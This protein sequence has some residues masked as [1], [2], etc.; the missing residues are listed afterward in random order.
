[1]NRFEKLLQTLC[2]HGVE[3]KAIKDI[4]MFRRG[5]FPQPYTRSKWYGG[6]NSMPFIQVIDVADTMKLNEKSKQSISKL[7]QPKSV[8]VPKGTVIV[9]LQGT[10]GKVAITQYDSYI[11]RTI[12]IFTSYR[13]N[14]DKKYFAYM[15]YQK[16]AMEKMLARGAT[17]KTITKEEF[18]D[19][20]IPLPPLE[21][22][23]EIVKILD[24]FTELNTE[25]NTELKLRKKQYEY[26]RNWLLSFG[27]VDA[28]KEGAEQRL[29]NKSYPKA[30]KALLLS[31]CPHGV[32]FRKLGEVCERSTGIN[33]TA[34]QMKKL[35]ETFNKTSSQR[36]IKIF[37]GG[38]TKVN[39]RSEDISE[40]SIINAESV[41]VKS[42]GNIGFEYCNEPFSHKNEIWSYS[43][44][45]NEAMIKFLH[46]YLA[47]K[48]DY[49][50][51]LAN[52]F[53]KMPQ[54]KVSHTDNL[55][56][57]LPPLEVQRE[58]VKILDDFS[59]L[60]EDLSSGI[61]AEIAARKKQYEYY[62]DKLLTFT[63]LIK[64]GE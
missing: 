1:M 63:P 12:A 60:T 56:I 19:F 62:R 8:F 6:D 35:Q 26:Y 10:I 15:L 38:E 17:L 37:G 40:K 34:A 4:A 24:T 30:L 50:Q 5:S 20:K 43:S 57:P 29:R 54:L 64:E 55:P 39:I 61:P 36:G 27:D 41:V 53:T 7:A 51:R 42:R 59:T 23:R 2:P 47:S 21:V 18:S 14:I 48:Q 3:F 31:L 49:F 11:D 52:E 28:S 46:Y 13:I 25:L 16:F 33:I 22:Q 44:K 9:T 58:I 45:T 32:E